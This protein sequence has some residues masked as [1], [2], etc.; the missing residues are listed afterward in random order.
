MNPP[1]KF[2]QL[3]QFQEKQ[4]QAWFT[5]MLPD[6]KYLL[7][8]GAA[9]GG[10]SYWLRWTA[11]GLGMYYYAKYGIKHV[12]IGLFSEDYPTLKD[13]QVIK[14]K[15]EIPPFLG[16]LVE[17]RDE[18]YIFRASPQYGEFIIL[19][20]NL[21][22]PSKYSSVEFAAILVEELTK[23][24][25]DTFDD[26]RFRLRYPGI[27]DVKFAAATNPGSV[28]HGFV[29]RLWVKP[30]P[31]ELDVEQDRFYFTQAL[32]S[33]NKFTTEG[34]VKQLD[35]L[36]DAK[37]RAYKEGDWDVFAGQYFQEWRDKIHACNPFIPSK[38]NVIIGGMDWGRTAPFSFHL[39]EVSKV[40]YN[41]K[42]FYRVRV[43]LE[44]YGTE[45][46][47]GE[48]WEVIEP[49][50][51]LYGL[52]PN[53]IAWIQGDGRMWVK[54][55]DGSIAIRDQFIQANS[56]FGHKLK[57]ASKDRI[58]GWDNYHKWLKIAPD[59]IPYYQATTDCPNLIR[60]VPELVHDKLKVEDVDTKGSDHAADDQRYMLKRL[61]HIDA[62]VG[63]VIHTQPR[64]ER[65]LRAPQFIK[66]KQVGIDTDAWAGTDSSSTQG[67][68]AIIRE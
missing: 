23:N 36:P 24:P 65:Q 31:N 34:Y 47:P 66:G 37:R 20:R 52:T 32:Y 68:G 25:R 46:T 51:K 60:E 55:D 53:D 45:K 7:Y 12:P 17:S 62:G 5:L 40:I 3:A 10:K 48:W 28:G 59:G 6:C 49:K 63:R 1:I 35:A 2:T 16:K 67:V 26:L 13:R 54:G 15:T 30:D 56:D 38:N 22:D 50:L 29:K 57:E 27:E 61:K 39:A 44:V 14:M 43:F 33:D 42:P 21:D 4:L 11:I 41:D 64:T 19:L 9:H 8:G 58:G 18:G